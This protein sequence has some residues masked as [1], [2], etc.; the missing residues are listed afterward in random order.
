MHT[1]ISDLP[2]P[3]VALTVLSHFLAHPNVY[4]LVA[5]LDGRVA[6]NNFRDERSTIAGIGPITVDPVVQNRAVG[7]ALMQH[8]LERLAQRRCPGVRWVQSAYHNRSLALYAKLGFVARAPLSL[9]RPQV[10]A[11]QQVRVPEA[12]G[13]DHARDGDQLA[14]RAGRLVC[15]SAASFSSCTRGTSRWVSIR[16]SS[17]PEMRFW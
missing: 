8:I 6:G 4:S 9:G 15:R 10:G 11:D 13:L 12:L 7:R 17:G 16:S 3:D 5:E 2:A 1:I 14:H